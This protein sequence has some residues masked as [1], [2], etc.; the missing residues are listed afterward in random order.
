[1]IT[2][3]EATFRNPTSYRTI[4]TRLHYEQCTQITN[5]V[6]DRVSV[7]IVTLFH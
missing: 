5:C 7:H 3:F 4:F 6:L 1:M 2:N